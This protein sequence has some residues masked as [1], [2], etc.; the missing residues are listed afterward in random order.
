[1]KERCAWAF[2]L[3]HRAARRLPRTSSAAR[4]L[5]EWAHKLHLDVN[6]ETD[7]DPDWIDT[8]GDDRHSASW[9]KFKAYIEKEAAT[10]NVRAENAE[11]S[12]ERFCRSIGCGAQET[13]IVQLA[14][15]YCVDPDAER[16]FDLIVDD[17]ELSMPEA[18]TLFT[19]LSRSCVERALSRKSV[20]G[21]AGI[22]ER[23][24][25]RKRTHF[26]MP[27]RLID[28]LMQ[29]SG[30]AEEVTEIL[31]GA[32]PDTKLH[33]KDFEHVC[34][35]IDLAL[36]IL[37]GALSRGAPGLNI[38]FYGAPGVGK[39]ELCSVLAEAL[40]AKLRVVALSSQ[41]REEPDRK[42]RLI[43]YRLAQSLL[44]R[45]QNN[46]VLFDE[47][48]DL[49]QSMGHGGLLFERRASGSKAFINR[50]LETN[51][52]PTLWTTNDISDVDPAILRRMTMAI[53]LPRPPMKAR[54]RIW[55]SISQEMGLSFS[56]EQIERFAK[57]FDTPPGLIATAVR[58]AVLAGGD[59]RAVERLLKQSTAL[60]GIKP[61]AKGAPEDVDLSLFNADT[62]LEALA[63]RLRAAG[64][65]AF[66]LCLHGAPGTGKTA[67]VRKL[68][69]M[70]NLS[71]MERRA[72]DLLGMYVGESE[73][74]IARAFRNAE[75]EGAFLVFDEA[76]S[77]L[78]SRATAQRRWEVSQVNEMLT[79]MERH[80]LPFACTTNL[81]DALDPASARR[82]TFKIEF[83]PLNR[84]QT[85]AAFAL[86]FGKPAPPSIVAHGA[87]T[88][89]DFAVV[90][91][92]A[93]IL[94]VDN[95]DDLAGML[96]SEQAY[97]N[98]P[99]GAIGFAIP[100]A[101]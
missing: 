72:S 75:R 43:E 91:R 6:G 28:A 56:D 35:D 59:E 13:E 88:L 7:D 80:P 101:N 5:V 81:I 54:T 34:V 9:G 33:L 61:P 18:V 69:E 25:E 22:L 29:S 2:K 86:Y 3:A 40:G 92:K 26:S 37:S 62:D 23:S 8:T 52:I 36:G 11:R 97:R 41:D 84:D 58:G 77:L 12:V 82:F 71:V 55:T 98:K 14:L 50:L 74:N 16:V 30:S 48:E 89:G 64:P 66:S 73:K 15:A 49:T 27:D 68:A 17:L 90:K 60:Q 38:L 24:F 96:I 10:P 46:I 57:T 87:S 1:M 45:D 100:A 67:Y 78:S 51:P 79:W 70:M 76:D 31:F 42:E 53:E 44:P 95:D 19:G 39:T 94:G 99:A 85:A 63:G 93:D 4:N 20:I 21:Q 65:S 32:A 83:R 47:M